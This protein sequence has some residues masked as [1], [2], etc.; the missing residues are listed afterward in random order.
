MGGVYKNDRD[1]EFQIGVDESLC[2]NFLTIPWLLHWA[3]W[4][5]SD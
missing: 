3:T 5:P 4:Y 1:R 2:N